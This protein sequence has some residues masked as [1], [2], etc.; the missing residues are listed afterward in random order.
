MLLR[1]T[2][3]AF[4]AIALAGL[5]TRLLPDTFPIWRGFLPERVSFPLTYWNAMGIACALGAL[6]AA[7][8]DRERRAS[9]A[10]VRVLAAAALRADRR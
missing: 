9:R 5:L 2:A 3:A 4:A 6:L 7:A 8:P 1:W 10:S